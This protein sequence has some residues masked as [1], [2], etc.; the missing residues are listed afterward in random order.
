MLPP[1]LPLDL[2]LEVLSWLEPREIGRAA[3]VS[4]AGR[5]ADR[6]PLLWFQVYSRLFRHHLPAP[7]RF[8]DILRGA[9]TALPRPLPRGKTHWPPVQMDIL[10]KRSQA[11]NAGAVIAM[12]QHTPQLLKYT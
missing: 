2:R 5:N 7:P 4:R 9:A 10:R 12:Q 8:R 1:D 11:I 6:T 3:A